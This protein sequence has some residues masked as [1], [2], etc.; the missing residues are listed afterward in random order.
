MKGCDEPSRCG[1]CCDGCPQGQHA[2]LGPLGQQQLVS[3][4]VGQA[5][6]CSATAQ[7]HPLSIKASHAVPMA[8]CDEVE[9][10]V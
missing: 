5:D 9:R 1:E 7:C 2:S 8:Q 10:K 6:H 4:L 3:E